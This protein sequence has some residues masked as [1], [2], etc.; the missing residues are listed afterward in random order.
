MRKIS[1]IIL[2]LLS[3]IIVIGQ[4]LSNIKNAPAVKIT[5]NLNGAFNYTLSNAS[6][7]PP[8]GYNTGVN[9]NFNFFNAVNI[10]LNFAYSSYGSSFNTISINRFG[11]SPSYKSLMVHAGHR[12]YVLS[13]YL[14]TGMTV[15]GGG[16]EFTPAKFNLLAFYGKVS[17]PYTLSNEFLNFKDTRVELYDRYVYGIRIGIGKAT[18]R[19]SIAAF[20]AEDAVNSGTTDTLRKYNIKGKENFALSTDMTQTLFDIITLSGSGAVS[21]LTNDVEGKAFEDKNAAEWVNKVSFL[22]NINST[23]RYAFAYDAKLSVRLN[24]FNV[25][26][27]YQHIDPYYSSLGVT[28]LQ[29]NFDNYLLDMS[30]SLFKSKLNLFSSFGLQN[31]NASG[32]TGLP[33][34]RIVANFNANLTISKALNLMGNYSNMV[35]NSTVKVEEVNDSLRITTNNRGW[36]GAVYFR[37]GKEKQPPHLIAVNLSSNTFDV[38]NSDTISLSSTND[39]LG[40]DYKYTMRNKWS[41]GGGFMY[42]QSNSNTLPSVKRYGI[43]LSLGKTLTKEL[44]FKANG[45]YRINETESIQDGYVINSSVGLSY[46][47]KKTHRFSVN[48]TQLIRKTTVLAAKQETRFR[49]NYNYSF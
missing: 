46:Q 35:Q 6:N 49:V 45:A 16:I 47:L 25:G 23:S 1:I 22:S 43:T 19:I 32:Y 48:A 15:F 24:T 38:I 9:I 28:Y 40:L 20:H 21:I 12:S 14:M 30:G 31:V 42:N 4:D 26:V 2:S 44:H 17:D 36:S 3:Y 7:I 41:F 8:I 27:R 29:N 37:P 10:P 11:I 34:K 18:N 5:G 13:P 33:Q 39:N